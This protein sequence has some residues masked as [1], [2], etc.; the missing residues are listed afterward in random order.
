M[1]TVDPL[2]GNGVKSV[3]LQQPLLGNGSA[4]RHGRNNSTEKR[5]Y[6]NNRKRSFLRGP[7][8]DVISM[9]NKELELVSEELVGE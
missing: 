6:K 9:S 2:L 1:W 7:H 3:T 5:G 8:R 4:N